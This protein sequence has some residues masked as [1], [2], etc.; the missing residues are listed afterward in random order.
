MTFIKISIVIHY[1]CSVGYKTWDGSLTQSAL[2]QQGWWKIHYSINLC[3]YQSLSL[4]KIVRSSNGTCITARS[5]IA[6]ILLK[7]HLVFYFLYDSFRIARKRLV[8]PNNSLFLK[9]SDST[10]FFIN[11]DFSMYQPD[12]AAVGYS[13]MKISVQD[14]DYYDNHL[15]TLSVTMATSATLVYDSASRKYMNLESRNQW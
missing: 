2:I 5:S 12:D 6:T 4:N 1:T 8:R 13:L 7:T 9:F 10:P 14:N 3:F 15:D 11:L